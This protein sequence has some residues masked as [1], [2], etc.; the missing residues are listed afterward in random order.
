M[1]LYVNKRY[2]SSSSETV[3]ERICT[4]D[5]DILSVSLRPFHLPRE[6]PQLFVTTVYIHPRA[7]VDSACSSI[8]EVVQ[9]LL[10]ISPDAPNFIM[11]DFNHVSLKKTLRNF[12]QYVTCPTRR[13]RTLDLCYGLEKDAYKSLPLAPLGRADH[14][15][16]HLLPTYKTV[17]KGVKVQTKD[18][19]VWTQEAVE[20]LQACFDCTDWDL[21]KQSC[22]DNFDA[23]V[24]VV[25]SYIVFCRDMTL[26]AD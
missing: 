19:R 1:C 9:K 18:I 16:V 14:N 2:C 5:A 26:Q 23:L 10:S 13:D 12:Y 25:C 21:F 4:K 6:F 3:R 15:C 24:H 8:F 11:G 22:G 7:N 17:L 20:R